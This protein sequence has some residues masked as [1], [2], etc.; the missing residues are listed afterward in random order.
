MLR[1]HDSECNS[2]I[3]AVS[4]GVAELECHEILFAGRGHNSASLP[5]SNAIAETAAGAIP[6][7]QTRP[8][9]VK[10]QVLNSQQLSHIVL[11]AATSP[12]PLLGRNLS[13]ARQ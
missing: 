5:A 8:R 2:S 11:L 1:A 7:H 9:C 10:T 6:A 13:H 4:S 3:G 12:A